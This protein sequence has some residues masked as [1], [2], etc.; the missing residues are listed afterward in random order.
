MNDA[1]SPDVGLDRASM[2]DLL[3]LVV[4]IGSVPMQ[5]GACLILDGGPAFDVTRA[6]RLIAERIGAVPRLRQ[7]LVPTPPGCGRPLWIDDPGFDL[8]H[9]LQVI[10]CP[11][12]GDEDALLDLAVAVIGRPLDRSK[13]LWTITLV[14][15][16]S[17]DRMALIACFHHVLADGIGSLAVLGCLVDGAPAPPPP[18]TFS[19]PVPPLRRVAADAWATRLRTLAHL[20][21]LWPTLKRAAAELGTPRR[22]ARCS[23][24]Q[25][26]GPRQRLATVTV[27]LY[28]IRRYAH[29]HAA[30][31]NDAALAAITGAVHALLRGRGESIPDLVVSVPV[32]ARASTTSARLG[33]EIGVMPVRLPTEGGLSDRLRR[34]AAITRARKST[35][36]GDST[37]LLT[38]VN[39]ILARLRLL[40]WLLNHQH[41]I[42]TAATNLRGPTEPVSFGGAV[43]RTIIPISLARGNVT[44]AFSMLSYAGILTVTIAADADRTPDLRVLIGALREEFAQMA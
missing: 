8:D 27:R 31:V 15:G 38:A 22:A 24:N 34:T 33:N 23:L 11:P 21:T 37:A 43:V 10:A 32:S 1:K 7:R 13:P 28:D 14:T 41:L 25:P 20:P 17:E 40:G 36:T 19:H 30:T 42:H 16:L 5:A 6:Q 9:H 44:I 39:R 3:N 2:G 35:A 18:A 26:V 29:A 12:P 4:D